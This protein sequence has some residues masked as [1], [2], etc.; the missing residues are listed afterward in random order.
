MLIMF[1]EATV[2]AGLVSGRCGVNSGE[3]CHQSLGFVRIAVLRCRCAHFRFR[4]GQFRGRRRR[5]RDVIVEGH[6]RGFDL[7]GADDR[8]LEHAIG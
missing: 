6:D 8:H 1:N 5:R 4:F 3:Q 7:G 2:S